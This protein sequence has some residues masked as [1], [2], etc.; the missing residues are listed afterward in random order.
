LFDQHPITYFGK[1]FIIEKLEDLQFKVSPKSFFQT[2]TKQAEKLYT[3]T[4]EFAALDG[5]QLVYDLYCGTGSIG[6]FVSKKAKKLVGVEV[7]A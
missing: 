4:R 6:L 1:G 2:N 7:V 3:V 5:S